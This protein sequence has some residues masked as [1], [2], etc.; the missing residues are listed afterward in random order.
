[1]STN[2]RN[3]KKKNREK[4]GIRIPSSA[5]EA[6]LFDKQNGNHLW[7]ESMMKEMT[8]LDESGCFEYYPPKHKFGK[9]YQYAPLRIIFDVKK[10]DLRRKSR[11]VAGGHVVNSDM[12]QSYA[13]VVQTRTVRL[14]ETVAVNEGLDVVTGDIG[15]AFVQAFTTEKVWSRCGKEFDIKEG[16]AIRIRKALYG[17]A[18]SARQWSLALGDV[19][20]EMGFKASRADP[21]LWIK[22]SADGKSYEY[23]ASHVDD[24]IIVCKDP[25]QYIE[26]IKKNFP[27]R[28]IE[29]NP[30]YYLGNDLEVRKDRTIKV[31][32]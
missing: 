5:R 11:L 27:I 14:L 17:M 8:A 2:K 32:M 28:K 20:K 15:N 31:S 13:S 29:K 12:Y 16:C 23:I 19:L 26:I 7:S 24:V 6:L 10:E 4:F 22:S 1:M 30:A 21:D 25:D 9:D 18:T 3:E